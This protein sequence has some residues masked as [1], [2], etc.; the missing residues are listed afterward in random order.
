MTEKM[1]DIEM[2]IVKWGCILLTASDNRFVENIIPPQPLPGKLS[3]Q[4]KPYAEGGDVGLAHSGN[5][6]YR[7]QISALP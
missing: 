4:C 5:R 2:G 1:N 3:L 7:N 6:S